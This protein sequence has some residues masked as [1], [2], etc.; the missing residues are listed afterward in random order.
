MRLAVLLFTVAALGIAGVWAWLGRPVPMPASPLGTDEKLFCVSYAPFRGSQNPLEASTHIPAAQIDED[1]ARLSR[2][3]NC[4]RTY[5]VQHGLDQVAGLAGKH[6]LKVMQGLWLS[7]SPEKNQREIAAVV[8]LAEQHKDVIASVVVGNEVLLRGEMSA[9]ELAATLRRVKAAVSVPV[10]YADV[11]EFW[12]RYREVFDASDFVTIHILPYW[13]DFPIAARDAAA[14]VDAIRARVVS[15]LP[16]KEVLIGEVGWPSWGR[17]REGALPSPANQARVLHEV[18]MAAKQ[19]GYRVNVIEAYD[20]PWKR[21]LEGTVGGHWGLFDAGSREQKFTWGEAVSN[22]PAWRVHAAA[23]VLLAAVVFLCAR[24]VSAG[25]PLQSTTW[26]RVAVVAFTAGLLVG[27]CVEKVLIESLGWGG[28]LRSG[29]LLAASVIVPPLCAAALARARTPATFAEV[30]RGSD[31][32]QS[33]RLEL[34][35]GAALVVVTALALH[36]ALGLVFDP[37]YKDFPFAGL[38]AALV[39]LALITARSSATGSEMFAERVAAGVLAFSAVYVAFNEGFLNW[40]AQAVVL[41][42]AL[43]AGV[44]IRFAGVRTRG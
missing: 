25:R 31:R 37:R 40:Q 19:G 28:W 35:L 6:N 11:W 29:I 13:E 18:L 2:I 3:T 16:G 44:L 12:L 14:H 4:I 42:L 20:Q 21:W 41:E 5:S 8:A 15:A 27:W 39:P 9:Q 23:G 1:L 22:H 10:T 43:L 26:V 38:G 34:C 36:T 7:S 30:L 24:L 17:M 33:G 32:L